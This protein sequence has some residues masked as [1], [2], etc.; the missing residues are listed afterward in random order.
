MG[1]KERNRTDPL[2]E[3]GEKTGVNHATTS[4]RKFPEKKVK[5]KE[6]WEGGTVSHSFSIPLRV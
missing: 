3:A 4:V 5:K 6:K 2:V 1:K